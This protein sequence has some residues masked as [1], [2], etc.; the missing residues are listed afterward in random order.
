MTRVC[1]SRSTRR[2]RLLAFAARRRRW[3]SVNRRRPGPS[4]SSEDAILFLERVNDVTLLLLIQP[5]TATTRNCNTGEKA[6]YG[7][8]RVEALGGHERRDPASIQ[9]RISPSDGVDR[10][11]DST[12]IWWS[13]GAKL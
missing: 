7:A 4:G 9:R 6:T 12:G 3:A 2:P 13:C 1:R 5:A 8:S 10:V 11:L